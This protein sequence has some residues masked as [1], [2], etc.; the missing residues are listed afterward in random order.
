MKK[1]K[2]NKLGKE[3]SNILEIIKNLNIQLY[4]EIDALPD[5]NSEY[6]KVISAINSFY[7]TIIKNNWDAVEIIGQSDFLE[8]FRNYK[9]HKDRITLGKFKT[10]LP[11]A[12]L[13][14]NEYCARKTKSMRTFMVDNPDYCNT[15]S[16]EHFMRKYNNIEIFS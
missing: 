4:D 9:S 6:R 12:E 2:H 16:I 15:R 14:Y 7:K 1:I 8:K 13:K 11:D 5:I 10:I 3:N